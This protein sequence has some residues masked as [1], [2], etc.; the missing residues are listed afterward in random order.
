[1][2]INLVPIGSLPEDRLIQDVRRRIRSSLN[3]IEDLGVELVEESKDQDKKDSISSFQFNFPFHNSDLDL[4]FMKNGFSTVKD[5]ELNFSFSK[6]NEAFLEEKDFI[7]KYSIKIS[8]GDPIE[9]NPLSYDE[10]KGGRLTEMLYSDLWKRISKIDANLIAGF[11]DSRL[12][13]KTLDFYENMYARYEE[14]GEDRGGA[15]VSIKDLYDEEEYDRSV[16]RIA[17]ALLHEIGHGFDLDHCEVPCVMSDAN[18]IKKLDNHEVYFCN[19]CKSTI[20]KSIELELE[21]TNG[22][23]RSNDKLVW[24]TAF[25][26]INIITPEED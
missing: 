25:S 2:K 14:Y 10:K 15:I 16:D 24:N 26:S 22:S 1:M 20:K 12:L 21:E 11:I 7:D 3:E 18:H 9:L 5:E 8:I 23:T 13:N 4:N 19:E 17:K 6:M